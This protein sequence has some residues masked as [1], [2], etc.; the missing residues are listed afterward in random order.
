MPSKL[1]LFPLLALSMAAF[2]AEPVHASQVTPVEW[3]RQQTPRHSK[4]VGSD[5]GQNNLSSVPDS[6]WTDDPHCGGRAGKS[7][8]GGA[9]GT[10]QRALLKN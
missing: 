10:P 9:A 3:L 2:A 8:D 7:Y 5:R 4:L 1:K 6:S